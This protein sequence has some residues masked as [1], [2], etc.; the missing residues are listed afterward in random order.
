VKVAQFGGG[1]SDRNLV[2]INKTDPKTN[3]QAEALICNDCL[4]DERKVKD[5]REGVKGYYNYN[6]DTEDISRGFADMLLDYKASSVEPVVAT[7][8]KGETKEMVRSTETG[9]TTST[10]K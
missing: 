10:K 7:G 2:K 8:T 5:V 6:P 3:K 1:F 9:K 4:K